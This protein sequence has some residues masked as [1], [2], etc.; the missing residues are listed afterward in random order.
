MYS[1]GE[2][3]YWA[4]RI[5][6]GLYTNVWKKAERSSSRDRELYNKTAYHV[7]VCRQFAAE[8]GGIQAAYP[9]KGALRIQRYKAIVKRAQYPAINSCV[10]SKLDV[11]TSYKT[12]TWFRLT[13]I[14]L[15]LLFLSSTVRSTFVFYQVTGNSSNTRNRSKVDQRR[16][17]AHWVECK[18]LKY[19]IIR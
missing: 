10:K 1:I 9:I 3:Q 17:V 12:Q 18:V 6:N 19:S 15:L 7:R 11:K 14:S 8:W 5:G 2:R 13:H 16:H 4:D